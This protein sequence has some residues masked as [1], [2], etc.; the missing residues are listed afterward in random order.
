MFHQG[1][2]KTDSG[3]HLVTRNAGAFGSHPQDLFN[4][5]AKAYK[6][7]MSNSAPTPSSF[8]ENK[9]MMSGS[10]GPRVDLNKSMDKPVYAGIFPKHDPISVGEFACPTGL[11]VEILRYV[12]GRHRCYADMRIGSAPM[13]NNS[14]GVDRDAAL[15]LSNFFARLHEVLPLVPLSAFES[16]MSN[17]APHPQSPTHE[18][19]RPD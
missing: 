12:G 9:I 5:A 19:E 6:S 17:K 18:S 7:L 10:D 11:L 4:A 8:K 1:Q 13:G 16:L 3:V 15:V 2:P 14:F